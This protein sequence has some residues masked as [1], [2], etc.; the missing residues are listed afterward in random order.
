MNNDS[1][2]NIGPSGGL[3]NSSPQVLGF[4]CTPCR[5]IKMLDNSVYLRILAE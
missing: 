2:L 5:R 4:L 1:V 3:G